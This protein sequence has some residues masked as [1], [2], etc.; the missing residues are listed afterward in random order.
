MI[1]YVWPFL[2]LSFVGLGT[3]LKLERE[4]KK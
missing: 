3:K 4:S 1:A 2:E